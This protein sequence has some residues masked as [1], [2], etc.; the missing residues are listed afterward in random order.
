MR[1]AIVAAALLATWGCGVRAPEPVAIDTRNDACA[2]CRMSVSDPAFAAQL[3]AP[4][5]EPRLFDDVGCLR[6]YLNEE[7]TLPRGAVAFVADHRTR[8]WV[9]AG[10]AT[11]GKV[12]DLSTLYP[13]LAILCMMGLAVLLCLCSEADAFVAA[14]FTTLHPSAKLGFLV[15]GPMFDLK[16][17][18]M[19][20]RVFRKRLILTIAASVIVQVFVYTLIVHF[21]WQALELPISTFGSGTVLPEPK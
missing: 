9:P 12:R 1:G 6:D 4:G 15:L 3:L 10:R 13:A 19:Y 16:L 11:Y 17:L 14:S 5:E 21:V 7:K 2:W 18:L 20:T 8:E